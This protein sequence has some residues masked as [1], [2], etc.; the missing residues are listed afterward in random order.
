MPA[1]EKD[2]L[3]FAGARIEGAGKVVSPRGC[4][5]PRRDMEDSELIYVHR[6]RGEIAIGEAVHP[7]RAGHLLAFRRG[8]PHVARAAPDSPLEHWYLHFVLLDEQ[9]APLDLDALA[10]PDVLPITNRRPFERLFLECIHHRTHRDGGYQALLISTFF[11]L[12]D[13]ILRA[14]PAPTPSPAATRD[15]AGRDRHNEQVM[16]AV[17]LMMENVSGDLVLDDLAAHA[18]MSPSH[19]E[20]VFKRVMGS[21]PHTYYTGV[22]M[23]RAKILMNSTRWTLTEIAGQLGF[24]SLHHFSRTFKQYEGEAPSRYAERVRGS[25]NGFA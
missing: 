2:R 6:G 11:L 3:S 23:E 13:H 5:F 17:H 14:A 16:S 8:E 7:A 18:R 12:L 15:D 9:G 22:K 10:L 24:G 20:K 21:S 25:Y 1:G 19:F 4:L